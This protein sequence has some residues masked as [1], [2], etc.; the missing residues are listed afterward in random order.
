MTKVALALGGNIGDTPEYFKKAMT[1]LEQSGFEI[2]AVASFHITKPVGC[3][4]GTPDF[5]NGALVGEWSGSA[6]ALLD[7][8]QQIEHNAGRPAEHDSRASRVLD[9]DI[10]L[11]GD[12]IVNSPRLIIPHPRMHMRRFVLEPLAEIAS[13]WLLPGKNQTVRDI[14]TSL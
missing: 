12:A 1:E 7:L 14:L 3:F 13:N 9:I 4:D 10:L 6:F 2:S 8:T 11:F 5:L